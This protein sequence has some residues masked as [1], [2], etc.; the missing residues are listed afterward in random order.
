MNIIELSSSKEDLSKYVKEYEL[1]PGTTFH[2]NSARPFDTIGK[3]YKREILDDVTMDAR[4]ESFR[5]LIF[6]GKK[7]FK[8]NTGGVGA[9]ALEPYHAKRYTK[10]GY[11]NNTANIAVNN[12]EKQ[13]KNLEKLEKDY[14]YRLERRRSEGCLFS[15]DITN[16]YISNIARKS[17]PFRA[18]ISK[19]D[20]ELLAR[21]DRSANVIYDI[22][23]GDV[24]EG[25]ALS[26]DDMT[27]I[28]RETYKYLAETLES[29]EVEATDDNIANLFTLS[30]ERPL[31]VVKESLTAM[32]F[33][34]VHKNVDKNLAIAVGEGLD[35]EKLLLLNVVEYYPT[36]KE[37]LSDLLKAP[38]DWIIRLI[39]L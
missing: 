14:E 2:I 22:F 33:L 20:K 1:R 17:T 19:G 25:I 13:L 35:Y 7:L 31:R 37:E 5:Q 23:D 24:E 9:V 29:V 38:S 3:S 32:P 8:E 12:V 30:F 10:P 16:N 26:L 18:A 4:A 39:G 15:I 36:N 27:L 34:K 6:T 21:Y 28:F 11:Y